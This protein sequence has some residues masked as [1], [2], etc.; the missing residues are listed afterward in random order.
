MEGREVTYRELIKTIEAAGWRFH[1]TG[2]GA[3][4]IYRHPTRRASIVVAHGAKLARDVP[5]GTLNAILRQ[6]GL[7]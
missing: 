7:K 5:T 2:A 4:M 6:A 3:H 1:R